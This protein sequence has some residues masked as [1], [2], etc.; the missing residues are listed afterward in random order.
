MP[1][2]KSRQA[3]N[4]FLSMGH[5]LLSLPALAQRCGTTDSVL[6]NGFI[7]NLTRFASAFS[8][9]VPA[10]KRLMQWIKG[11]IDFPKVNGQY[12]ARNHSE[13]RSKMHFRE[14]GHV[15]Q[16]IRTTYDAGSK[17][18]KNEIVGRLA[19]A[20]IKVS[21]EL[22]AALKPDERKELTAWIEGHAT[23]ERLK[24]ELA[25]RTLPE[26]LALAK[27]WFKGQKGD[28]ARALA[29]ALI[30]AWVRFRNLLKRNGLVE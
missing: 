19:R 10:L 27:E 28:D 12:I 17:K 23:V 2:F 24:R 5:T 20:N 4:G 25:V 22:E 14:R 30:P 18:G 29:A 26:Q 9:M 11:R 8:L 3:R 7:R 1:I 15:V 21:E 13:R 6:P 16:L